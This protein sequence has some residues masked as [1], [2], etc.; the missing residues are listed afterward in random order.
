M[1]P[2]VFSGIGE[3]RIHKEFVSPKVAGGVASLQGPALDRLLDFAA[4]VGLVALVHNDMN[5]PFPKPGAKPA[6]LEQM[7]ALLNRDAHPHGL[8]LFGQSEM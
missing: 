6:Y 1:F 7:T 2:G 5:T 4:A 8:F 3:F